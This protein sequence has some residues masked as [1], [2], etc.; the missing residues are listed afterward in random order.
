M[1]PKPNDHRIALFINLGTAYGRDV[2]RGVGDLTARGCRCRFLIDPQDPTAVLDEIELRGC[3]GLIAQITSDLHAERLSA[4]AIPVVNTTD[5]DAAQHLPT[6]APDIRD[7]GRVAAEHL[8]ERGLRRFAYVPHVP[9]TRVDASCQRG[10][11]DRLARDGLTC[12]VYRPQVRAHDP[13]EAQIN[14]LS[15]WLV[16]LPKPCGILAADHQ[17]GRAVLEAADR[18]PVSVPNEVAVVGVGGD[19]LLNR[20]T[21]PHLSTVK[22]PSRKIGF[23]AAAL[24]VNLIQGDPPPH[25]PIRLPAMHVNVMMS[26]DVTAISDEDV[27]AVVRFIRDNAHRPIQVSDLLE[28]VPIS[29]R[30]L[31]RRFQAALGRTPQQEIQRVRIETAQRLLVETDQA[32]P[33]VAR[34]SGFSSADRLAAVFRQHLGLTPSAFRNRYKTR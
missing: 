12:R 3:D 11:A 18:A 24:L 31:E 2:L 9:A 15:R 1:A 30:S 5:H 33:A 21:W 22:L 23:E 34:R 25:Q 32:V 4:L 17:R 7:V 26:S 27:A 20:I 29:R 6:V 14:D 13:P 28:A 19:E 10:F 16:A 8:A